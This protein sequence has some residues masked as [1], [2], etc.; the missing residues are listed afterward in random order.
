MRERGLHEM[1]DASQ[2]AGDCLFRLRAMFLA[3]RLQW[4]ENDPGLAHHE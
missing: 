2:N 4:S 1:A 3:A